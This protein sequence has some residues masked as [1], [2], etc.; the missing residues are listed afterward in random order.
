[1][2]T[3]AWGCLAEQNGELLQSTNDSAFS[4]MA[5]LRPSPCV[6][7]TW[8]WLSTNGQAYL[9]T[10]AEMK[11]FQKSLITVNNVSVD[12]VDPT[13]PTGNI[14]PGATLKL[15]GRLKPAKWN[16]I[17]RYGPTDFR[18]YQVTCDGLKDTLGGFDIHEDL[19]TEVDVSPG[20]ELASLDIF[21][22]PVAIMTV[23]SRRC[24]SVQGLVLTPKM[25][26]REIY[27]R[28]AC[29]RSRSEKVS[30]LFLE[31]PSENGGPLLSQEPSDQRLLDP[32]GLVEGFPFDG[33]SE[34]HRIPEKDII[35]V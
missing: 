28:V 17:R 12:L 21:L 24:G 19:W 29:F 32:D 11:D 13:Y 25:L 30:Y 34:W 18:K 14:H 6:A 7:P 3:Q 31:R 5:G 2:S 8:S 20:L 16:L 4:N 26:E 27:E 35:V 9:K 1:M 23:A 10:T 33:G 15:R 22:L